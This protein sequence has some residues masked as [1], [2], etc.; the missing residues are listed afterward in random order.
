MRHTSEIAFVAERF[1][2]ID[3]FGDLL[4]FVQVTPEK[5]NE[6]VSLKRYNEFY[7]PKPSGGQRLI[8][9]PADDLQNLQHTVAR[10]LQAVYH[11]IRSDA[12][13]AFQWALNGDVRNTRTNALRH[14]GSPYM[15]KVDFENYFHQINAD[16]IAEIFQE[17]PFRFKNPEL[18]EKLVTLCAYKGRL[19]MGAPTSPVLA[20]LALHPL[21]LLF[22]TLAFQFK[23]TYTRYA[24]DLVF[25]SKEPMTKAHLAAIFETIEPFG[26]TIKQ[27][28]TK[29]WGPADTK[30]VTGIVLTHDGLKLEESYLEKLTEEIAIYFKAK[31]LVSMYDGMPEEKLRKHEQKIE[32]HIQYIG[33]IYGKGHAVYLDFV[34]LY[35]RSKNTNQFKKVSWLDFNNYAFLNRN[36]N[37]TLY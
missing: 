4:P 14:L 35:E 2:A 21:D 25:S 16:W 9:D 12:S 6:I 13:Y 15:I 28:K 30:I 29:I 31:Q 32:G 27:S 7:V 18:L 19:P 20:N 33:T 3:T 22:E 17:K 5:F 26:L 11:T 36:S 8:E 10:Y 1:L 23:A 24:D 34:K 37:D